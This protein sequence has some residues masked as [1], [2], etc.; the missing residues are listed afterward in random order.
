MIRETRTDQ[1]LVILHSVFSDQGVI[2]AAEQ[3]VTGDAQLRFLRVVPRSVPFTSTMFRQP[4]PAGATALPGLPI[5]LVTASDDMAGTILDLSRELKITLLAIGE[6]P[7]ERK[8]AD[9]V[10][11]VLS[12]ILTLPSPPVL[13]VP[14]GASGAHAP[15]RRI[16]LVLHAPYPA[17]SLARLAVPLARRSHAEL[18]ILALPPAVPIIPDQPD[19][20]GAWPPIVFRPFDAR[21]WLERECAGSGCRIRPVSCDGKIGD[22]ILERATELQADLVMADSG[23]ADVRVG[24]RKRRL[25]DQLFPRLTCPLLLSRAA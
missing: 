19:W 14:S 11:R 7:G 20:T 13:Y 15:L 22:V 1:V 9:L 4:M 12:R 24:W 8:R 25:L 5:R 23:L 16:L 3:L 17:M 2:S 6:P 18:M 21:G 10:R